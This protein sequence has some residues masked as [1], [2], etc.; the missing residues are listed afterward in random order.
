MITGAIDS[1]IKRK[2]GQFATQG[3]H[4]SQNVS[5][6]FPLMIICGERETTEDLDFEILDAIKKEP[7]EYIYR[8]VDA[9]MT[10]L[11]EGVC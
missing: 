1:T 10:V 6:P 7:V 8:L 9:H 3:I 2:A 4:I 5:F 11:L